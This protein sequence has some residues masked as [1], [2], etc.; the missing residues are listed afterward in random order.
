MSSI[1]IIGDNVIHRLAKTWFFS[2]PACFL[3]KHRKNR[4]RLQFLPPLPERCAGQQSPP[5]K[6]WQHQPGQR[7]GL[8][9]AHAARTRLDQ[10]HQP[11]QEL[12]TRTHQVRPSLA[13]QG[14]ALGRVLLCV[15]QRLRANRPLGLAGQALAAISLIAKHQPGQELAT[16]TGSPAQAARQPLPAHRLATSQGAAHRARSGARR[17]TP[18]Q[19]LAT[20]TGS[21]ATARAQAGQVL[22]TSQGTGH[23]T[24]SSASVW[25]RLATS[26]PGKGA[27]APAKQEEK[28]G[29][30][31]KK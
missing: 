24:R 2:V 5:A 22:A 4:Q 19:E 30:L 14:V 17:H 20:S 6:G 21:T 26:T 10:A 31:N 9:Q 18:G 25:P 23:R 3:L 13:G 1:R 8:D 11:G 12:A 28:R 16:S 27:K 15:Q 29:A 7:T